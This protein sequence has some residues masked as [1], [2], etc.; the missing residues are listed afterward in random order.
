MPITRHRLLCIVPISAAYRQRLEAKYDLI[1]VPEGAIAALARLDD[2]TA[3]IRAVFTNGSTGISNALLERMPRDS[4]VCCTGVGF[5]NVDLAFARSRGVTVTHGPGLND[6]TVADHA[7]AL[8]LALARNIVQLDAATRA[9]K[10]AESRTPRPTLSGQRLGIV[11]LGHIGQRI[12]KRASAFDMS[13]GY[14]SRTERPELGLRHFASLIDL[15]RASDYLVLSCPGGPATRHMINA[16]V[17]AALGP[18][19]YLIN[20]ARGSVVDTAALVT[21]LQ[22]R[23]IAG[24][25]LDVVEGEPNI[26]AALIACD[27]VVLSPHVAGRSPN[28][29]AAALEAVLANLEAFFA[30]RPVLT[31][32][33][34]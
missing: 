29:H 5:E 16:E 7:L 26:P 33:P 25:A 22:A 30:G 14:Y 18:N 13:I 15:A 28:A 24:A 20:V 19:S 10:F 23:A 1:E 8:M 11:G 12:A 3:E 27:N 34:A 6:A 2:R 32:V 4:I 9:G 17:L 31:P 21:A